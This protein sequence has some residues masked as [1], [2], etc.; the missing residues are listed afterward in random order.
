MLKDNAEFGTGE[1]GV[2]PEVCDYLAGKKISMIG[3]DTWGLEPFDFAKSGVPESFANCHMNLIVRR[4]IYNFENLDLDE[5]SAD[6]AYEF[7]FARAPFKLVGAT[8]SP[9]NPVAA[10]Q[11]AVVATKRAGF[12][13]CPFFVRITSGASPHIGLARPTSSAPRIQR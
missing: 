1:P 2:S 12:R 3:T 11:S 9:G 7:L 5:L 6:K 10:Y 13:P 4:G 8:G